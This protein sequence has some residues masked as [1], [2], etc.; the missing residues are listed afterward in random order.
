MK[1]KTRLLAG[2]MLAA[3]LAGCVS[4]SGDKELLTI[5][6]KA[7]EQNAGSIAQATLVA[8]GDATGITFTLGGVPASV[9]RPLQL[10]TF[11][12]S[13]TCD[14]LSAEPT[15]AMNDTTQTTPMETG[16]M[17]SREVPVALDT[18]RSTPHAL[19]VRTSPADGNV[20]IFCGNI[21][22]Q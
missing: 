5:R 4:T 14:R 10:Y 6:L 15:Y 12:Y 17:L 9:S 20:D 18:L 2:G 3:L 19:V 22:T 21:L 1:I 13:G 16:W 11:V 8:R 7:G